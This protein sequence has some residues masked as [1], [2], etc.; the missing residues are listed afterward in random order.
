MIHV[1]IILHVLAHHVV[2]ICVAVDTGIDSKN[3]PERPFPRY[4][5][6]QVNHGALWVSVEELVDQF[7]SICI[8]CN[9]NPH[10]KWHS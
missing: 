10:G 6:S 2:G 8:Q 3:V 1:R 4:G 7:A 5:H 9:T